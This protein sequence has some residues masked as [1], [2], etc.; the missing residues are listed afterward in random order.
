MLNG[1]S[2]EA[3]RVH[4]TALWRGRPRPREFPTLGTPEDGIPFLAGSVV[5]CPGESV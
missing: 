2:R 5:G 3:S 4:Y 1:F